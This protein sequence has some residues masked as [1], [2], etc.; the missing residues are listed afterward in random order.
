M[1]ADSHSLTHAMIKIRRPDLDPFKNKEPVNY[2]NYFSS[3]QQSSYPNGQIKPQ[4]QN[5]ESMIN[6]SIASSSIMQSSIEFSQMRKD[7]G[8]QSINKKIY[9]ARFVKESFAENYT[10]EQGKKFEKVWTFRNEGTEAW[11]IDT[12]FIY[13]NGDQIGQL[14][15]KIDNEIQAGQYV[16]ISVEF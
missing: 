1:T 14:E 4:V 10:V 11:P 2:S 8:R 16:D 6:D 7:G 15:K 3:M 12:R 5:I 13:T 9:K